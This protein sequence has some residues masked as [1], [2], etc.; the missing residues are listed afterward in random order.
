MKELDKEKLL[1][2]M[3]EKEKALEEIRDYREL[4]RIPGW[5]RLENWMKEEINRLNESIYYCKIEEVESYR[6]EA[7]GM[8]NMLNHI[9]KIINKQI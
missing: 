5:I 8:Q 1:I 4:V 6:S 7:R 3:D 9:Y 2:P